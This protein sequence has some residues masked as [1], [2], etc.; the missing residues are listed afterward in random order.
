MCQA[1]VAFALAAGIFQVLFLLSL[2]VEAPTSS[3]ETHSKVTSAFGSGTEE[4][5][6]RRDLAKQA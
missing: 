1:F 4:T 5:M 2:S 3:K 6:H